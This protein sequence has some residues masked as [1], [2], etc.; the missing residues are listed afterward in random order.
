MNVYVCVGVCV[1][2][3]INEYTC[4]YVGMCVCVYMV[5][6]DIILS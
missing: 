2:V 1:C 5:V 6:Y 4:L 3:D